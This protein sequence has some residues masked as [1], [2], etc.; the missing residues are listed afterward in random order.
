MD[1]VSIGRAQQLTSPNPFALVS[2]S[3]SCGKNNLAAVSWWT[4][5]SNHPAT[6]GICLS[7][8]GYSGKL[9]QETGAFCLCV[10]DETLKEA[11]F[12]CGTCSGASVDKAEAFGIALEPSCD[13]APQ[14]VAHSRLVLE[15]RL[16]QSVPVGDHVFYIGEVLGAYANST[17]QGLY[18]MDGY[19]SLAVVPQ[20]TDR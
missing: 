5:L 4:Y 6:V 19:R 2:T 20:P 1:H 7:Q 16:V 13:I 18:A 12:R 11:A 8:K 15:C 14:R 10:P 3:S 9:I 17:A